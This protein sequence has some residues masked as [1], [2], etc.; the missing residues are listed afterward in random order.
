MHE[1]MRKYPG[2]IDGISIL[3]GT[4]RCNANCRE[5]A[6]R[7]H[8]KSAPQK[9]GELDI[10]RLKQVLEFCHARNC[11]YVTLTGCGEP[12]LSPVS[13][14]MALETIRQFAPAEGEA[15]SPRWSKS[16]AGQGRLDGI[17]F[18]PVNLYTNGIRI[19]TDAQFCDKFLPHWQQ[20][21]LTS[22]YVSTYSDNLALNADA[23]R[24]KAYPPFGI[25]FTRLKEYGLRV[26]VSVILKNGYTDT[27]DKFQALSERFLRLGVDN[28]T[29]WP[30][31]DEDGFIS[32]LA[33]SPSVLAAINEYARTS[34]GRIRVLL[35]DSRT[36]ESLVRKI[37][38]FQ[39]GEI[40]DVWCARK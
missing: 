25:I 20:L 15:R 18:N 35:G 17:S 2:G 1:M 8:R 31:K 13:L 37:A 16:E 27:P 14:T 36:K 4:A 30:L 9:D 7:Q 11:H 21:G 26:R 12:T 34:N 40:S 23:F 24:V 6:G 19:G 3:V 32:P 38:L 5:C 28:V 10:A 33:P 22:V 39:N 29:A